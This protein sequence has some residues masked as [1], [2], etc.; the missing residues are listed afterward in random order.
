MKENVLIKL[1][2]LE[3]KTQ[4]TLLT[5]KRE[6]THPYRNNKHD[7]W[8]DTEFRAYNKIMNPQPYVVLVYE[9]SCKHLLA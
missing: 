8:E 9:K 5:T 1:V 6:A 7:G 4:L 3:N 2:S